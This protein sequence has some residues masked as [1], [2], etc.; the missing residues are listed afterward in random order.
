M[1]PTKQWRPEIRRHWRLREPV[2]VHD[3]ASEDVEAS[4]VGMGADRMSRIA[5]RPVIL[6]TRDVVA[7]GRP[8]L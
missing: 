5:R 4:K 2:V 1:Q 6:V 8:D 3:S 7:I